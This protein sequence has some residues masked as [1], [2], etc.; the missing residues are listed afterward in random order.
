V[1]RLNFTSI[2]LA[3]AL[4]LNAQSP[5][6]I[7]RR[8]VERD[9]T[10]F[11]S[12]KNYTY[13]QRSE[14][15]RYAKDGKVTSKESETHEILVLE[16]RRYERQIAREDKP[17]SERDARRERDKLEREVTK[18]QHESA[19]ERARWE[20]NRVRDREFVREIPEAFVFRLVGTEAVS[21]QP[22]W[23]IEADPKPG[24]RPRNSQAKL[25]AKVRAK[26]WIEQATYHWVKV[27]AQVLDTLS[28]GLGLLRIAPGGTMHFEQV[29][30]NE[31]VWL[32]SLVL[33]RANARL[34]LLQVVRA[35]L[36]L[37][38]SGYQKFQSDT[39][40]VPEEN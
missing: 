9:W 1:R 27:D 6:D 23:V 26:I 22:A 14:S 2:F 32:P 15:R 40:F 21:G 16:G 29:R 28:F 13:E 17:L 34:A 35:E 4:T 33:V 31:E 37:R 3:A 5:Y 7:V 25:F 11:A 20:R 36:E 30:V 12:R 18:R 38:Y 8:S 19:A 24:Y 39:R 10:D